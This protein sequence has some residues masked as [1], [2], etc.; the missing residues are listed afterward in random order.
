M[1][2]QLSGL[3]AALREAVLDEAGRTKVVAR[4][5][6]LIT[7]YSAGDDLQEATAD[8]LFALLDEEL[9]AKG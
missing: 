9:E 7:A 2:S 5:T 1:D 4:L 6:A 3:E 8:E